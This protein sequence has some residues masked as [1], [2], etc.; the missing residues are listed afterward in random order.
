MT[1]SGDATTEDGPTPLAFAIDSLLAL[2]ALAEPEADRFRVLLPPAPA[3][4]LSISEECCLAEHPAPEDA[5][6]VACGMG[7][8]L[9]ERLIEASRERRGIAAGR[10]ESDPPRP[11]QGRAQGER[12]AVRNAPTEVRE[13][14]LTTAWYLVEYVTW[15]AEADDRFEGTLV[16][17]AALDDLAAP[18]PTLVAVLDAAATAGRLAPLHASAVRSSFADVER[19]LRRLAE[20][21]VS[22][23]E[24]A[25]A[26]PTATIARRLARDHARIA[27]HFEGMAQAARAPRRKV[28][29][30]TIARKLAH[31]ERERD[32][33]LR[34]LTERYA[35]RVRLTPQAAV[36]VEVPALRVEVKVRRRKREGRLALRLPAGAAA[37]DSLA[38]AGCSG[39]ALRPALCDDELHVLCERCVTNA[40]GR[41]DCPACA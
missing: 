37:L 4:A 31:L 5:G 20:G 29:P 30:A 18:D 34:E 7:S 1:A 41:F 12:L 13:I 19:A 8:P 26:V 9:L 28:D 23:L 10:L 11:A 36:V 35:L 25:L 16:G 2:G 39:W 32:G 3:V 14:S 21:A 15:T 24:R 38:C 27:E 22:S 6:V 33:K 40:Q 17:A